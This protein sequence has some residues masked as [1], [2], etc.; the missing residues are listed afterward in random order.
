MQG[1]F[2]MHQLITSYQDNKGQSHV[3]IPTDA[4][5]ALDKIQF[6]FMMESLNKLGVKEWTPM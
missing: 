2:I 1:W 3:I 4:G 5:K 6:P